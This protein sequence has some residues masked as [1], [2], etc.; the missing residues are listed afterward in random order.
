MRFTRCDDRFTAQW[1]V[2]AL[3]FLCNVVAV[4]AWAH[5]EAKLELDQVVRVDVIDGLLKFDWVYHEPPQTTPISAQGP[6]AE[7][8]LG[9]MRAEDGAGQALTLDRVVGS[10]GQPHYYNSISINAT[11]ERLRVTAILQPEEFGRTQ[12]TITQQA[13]GPVTLEVRRREVRQR[14][15]VSAPNLLE[16]RVDQAELFSKHITP[17]LE[18]LS[19][20]N[21]LVPGAADVYRVFDE[22]TP[23][24]STLAMVRAIVP[25]LADGDFKVRK[26]ATNELRELGPAG[27]CALTRIDRIGLSPEAVSRI[28]SVLAEQSRRQSE[29]VELLRRNPSFLADCL[30]FPDQRVKTAAL[31]RIEHLTGLRV[32]PADWARAG[33]YVRARIA[34]PEANI[35]RP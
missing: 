9:A 14:T 19:R 27:I 21:L 2:R 5:A 3:L 32:P 1:L 25:R 22:I 18:Q 28:E 31:S 4:Q 29:Q 13:G 17:L 11:A 33:Q 26:A 34:D 24:P 7:W 15:R 6:E 16:L 35:S 23:D 10:L 8:R 20:Q 12:V 30:D